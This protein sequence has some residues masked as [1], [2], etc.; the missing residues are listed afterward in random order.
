MLGQINL[1][2]VYQSPLISTRLSPEFNNSKALIKVLVR[3]SFSLA[4]DVFTQVNQIIFGG[5]YN[6]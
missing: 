2:S 1:I 5:A 3:I 6:R 4:L